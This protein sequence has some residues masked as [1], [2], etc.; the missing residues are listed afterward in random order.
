[1]VDCQPMIQESTQECDL[2]REPRSK[3]DLFKR[4]PSSITTPGPIMTFGPIE[5]PAPM[6]AVGSF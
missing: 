1:M 2:M 4:T 5:Q 6:T 3:V